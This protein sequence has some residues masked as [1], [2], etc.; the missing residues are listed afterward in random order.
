VLDETVLMR[1]FGDRA[2]MRQQLEHLLNVAELPNVEIRIYPLN[3]DPPSLPIG[4]FSYMQFPQVHDVPL[5]DI[6]SV[7][8]LD[9]NYDLEDENETFRY[10]V[11]FQ[12]L[13]KWA[14]DPEQSR[15][16]IS[17]TIRDGWQ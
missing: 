13:A 1:H 14:L 12:H 2:V 5:H 4:A 3:R 11:A 15:A 8:S 9:G 6:V 17:A 16:L 7:E 10:G